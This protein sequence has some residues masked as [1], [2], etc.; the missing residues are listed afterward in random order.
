MH[1]DT[2]EEAGRFM[3]EKVMVNKICD[4]VSN[5]VPI[6]SDPKREIY[7]PSDFRKGINCTLTSASLTKIIESLREGQVQA[8]SWIP[9]DAVMTTVILLYTITHHALS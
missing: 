7:K 9:T 4:S 5:I 8:K 3:Q 6:P 1:C 2:V